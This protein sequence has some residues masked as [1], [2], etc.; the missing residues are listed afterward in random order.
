MLFLGAPLAVAKKFS[1]KFK[2]SHKH[3]VPYELVCLSALHMKFGE[4]L[5]LVSWKSAGG[6][7]C[8]CVCLCVVCASSVDG[9]EK[10]LFN[11]SGLEDSCYVLF[12]TAH[13]L[14]LERS[15]KVG[16]PSLT[17]RVRSIQTFVQ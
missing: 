6:I 12:L 14:R 17:R 13:L 10:G 3:A 4:H 9:S 11:I 1:Q 8:L 15:S 16:V 5:Y 2:L 7:V